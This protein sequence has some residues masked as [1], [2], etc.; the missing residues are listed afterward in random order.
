[1]LA[2][3]G[4]PS[5]IL[6]KKCIVGDPTPQDLGKPSIIL[7][8]NQ[9]AI[10]YARTTITSCQI[11][12]TAASAGRFFPLENATHCPRPRQRMHS[13]KKGHFHRR[14][15]NQQPQRHLV[16]GEEYAR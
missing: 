14:N 8:L 1:M 2:K 12:V 10:Y 3:A 16:P 13:V 5:Y 4:W 11:S 15:V 6:V 7:D 9:C